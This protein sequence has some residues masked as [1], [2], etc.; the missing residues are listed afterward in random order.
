MTRAS[1]CLLT[2][3][4]AQ[5]S[6]TVTAVSPQEG[7]RLENS[8][9]SNDECGKGDS[10]RDGLCQAL[11][12]QL[13]SVLIAVTPPVQSSIPHLTFVTNLPD[14]PPS[15]GASDLV[16]P[17]PAGVAGSLALPPGACYPTFISDDPVHPFLQPNDR[18]IPVAATLTLRQRLLGLPQQI[19]H[20]EA[21]TIPATGSYLFELQV[22]GGEYDV[23][24][25]PHKHAA[26]DC[27][28]PPQ[29]YRA[30]PIGVKENSQELSTYLFSISGASWLDL[31]IFWPES[32]S[33]LDGWTAD[34][35][36]PI[37]GRAISTEVELRNAKA[38]LDKKVEYAARLLYSSVVDMSGDASVKAAS[39]LLRLRPPSGVVAPTVFLFR[40][41][42]A[43]LQKKK[44][45]PIEL[46]VFNK[47]P[48][49]V[50]VKGQLVRASDGTPVEGL[51]TLVSTMIQGMDDGVFGSYQTTVKV[52]K[53]GNIDVQLPPGSYRVQAIPP[54][55]PGALGPTDSLAVAVTTWEVPL[56]SATQFGKLIELPTVAQVTGQSRVAGA[57]VQAVPSPQDVLPFEDAIGRGDFAPRSTAALVDDAGRFTLNVDPGRFDVTIQ[58]AEELG[59][60]W[61]VRPGVSLGTKNEDLGRLQSPTPSILS[62]SIFVRPDTTHPLA[63]A[64]VRA[65]AYLD[66]DLRYTRDPKLAESVIQVAETRADVNGSYRLLLPSTIAA[67]K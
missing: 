13:E 25:E 23:Y 53:D 14:V 38:A 60:G 65:Y 18:S 50:T 37:G 28:A 52:A 46:T 16:L 33:A 9:T 30:F 8:C 56:G 66:K 57:Q 67:P 20:A 6:C 63:S 47:Y 7:S 2:L 1:W 32:S 51:V 49:P 39:E 45:D 26:G 54:M 35:I 58:T 29:L 19:Y 3:L 15:G 36:E 5:V 24:L 12:G 21:G 42:L 11:N 17:G 62:G 31:R 64:N 22:P 27:L 61:F 43:L 10:C 44:E 59:F 34:I 4:L 40:S 55:P 48:A 41:V